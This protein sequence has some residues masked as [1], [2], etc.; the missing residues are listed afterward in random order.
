MDNLI[1]DFI[2]RMGLALPVAI[3]VAVR[4]GQMLHLMDSLNI[5]T[6]V[7]DVTI[8]VI[9]EKIIEQLSII[10]R[11]YRDTTPDGNVNLPAEVNLQE[12]FSEHFFF[13]D[14]S[15]QC[16]NQIYLDL[17]NQ[18]TQSPHFAQALALVLSL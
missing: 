7:T 1:A 17:V 14:E 2:S 16:L 10:F 13:R 8:N 3:L 6:R 15:F 12:L 11:V 9:K 18:G 5:E 4:A